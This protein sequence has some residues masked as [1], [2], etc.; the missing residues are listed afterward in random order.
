LTARRLR[1]NA[2]SALAGLPHEALQAV[3]ARLGD[4]REEARQVAAMALAVVDDDEA[5]T[6]LRRTLSEGSP[7]S[8]AAA[9]IALRQRVAR[10]RF[11]VEEAWTLTRALLARPDPVAR[12]GG[13]L[14]APV[15]TGDA[16]EPAVR[17][18]LQ[19]ADPD[20]A[21]S[22]R[23]AVDAIGNVRKIDSAH[24]DAAP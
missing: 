23:E 16:V 18:L 11:P 1:R 19:D 7:A 14:V 10:G 5:A 3:C 15:F 6:C 2:A 8:Q 20:V 22:A 4:E 21:A 24:G 12:I 9:A 17:P 13:L